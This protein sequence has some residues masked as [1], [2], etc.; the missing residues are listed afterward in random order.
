MRV[1]L[2]S[3]SQWDSLELVRMDGAGSID[4]PDH[5]PILRAVKRGQLW[6]DHMDLKRNSEVLLPEEEGINA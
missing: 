4:C 3:W 6:P 2:A 1:S 5:G